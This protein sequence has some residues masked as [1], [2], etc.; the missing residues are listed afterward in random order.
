MLFQPRK[1]LVGLDILTGLRSSSWRCF[2]GKSHFLSSSPGPHLA[3][4]DVLVECDHF[5]APDHLCW[6]GFALLRQGLLHT[7]TVTYMDSGQCII[8]SLRFFLKQASP[9]ERKTLQSYQTTNTFLTP[10][11]E[12]Y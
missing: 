9:K 10:T 4:E 12:F 8:S 11:S 3:I 2:S 7:W 1:R 6:P 5:F